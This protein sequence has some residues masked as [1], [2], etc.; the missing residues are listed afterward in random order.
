MKGDFSA[1]VRSLAWTDVLIFVLTEP[2]SVFRYV[3]ERENFPLKASFAVPA[4]AALSGVLSATLTS[5][6]AGFPG[7]SY[8]WIFQF[9]I[10]AVYCIGAS[11]LMDMAAQ[12]YGCRGS[13]R[14]LLTVLNLSLFPEIF[15]LPGV[16]IFSVLDFA[17]VFFFGFF[18]LLLFIWSSVILVVNV[19][20]LYGIGPG[21]A[22]LIC[23][24]PVILYC[25]FLFFSS[26]IFLTGIISGF[27]QAL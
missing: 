23:I 27:M 24:F 18:H 20:G 2:S 7:I 22:F 5:G 12:F 13:V 1:A 3:T 4:A 11:A 14:S 15:L 25:V 19:S 16:F 6:T 9:I 21:R 17:P 10:L 26:V 8:G